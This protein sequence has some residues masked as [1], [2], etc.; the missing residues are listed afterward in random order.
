MKRLIGG[1]RFFFGFPFAGEFEDSL[2]GDFCKS[3]LSVVA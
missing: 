1:W 2:P 3:S